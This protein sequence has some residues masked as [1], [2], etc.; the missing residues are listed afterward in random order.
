MTTKSEIIKCNYVQERYE[1]A[2]Y[3]DKREWKS[4]YQE[5]FDFYCIAY[6]INGKG[7]PQICEMYF[8]E[9]MRS[10]YLSL[11]EDTLLEAM[12]K[13]AKEQEKPDFSFCLG[14]MYEDGYYV[15]KNM[16]LQ[17]NGT[18]NQRKGIASC[19]LS[20]SSDL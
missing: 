1:I 14:V 13:L 16:I 12:K 4:L 8:V 11:T 15:E 6:S 19:L 2:E 20:I 7:L 9:G 3:I 10:D 17:L 5:A 18:K